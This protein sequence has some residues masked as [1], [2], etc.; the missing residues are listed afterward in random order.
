[1]TV[2]K[3]FHRFSRNCGLCGLFI[4]VPVT[5]AWAADTPSD[6]AAAP[7]LESMEMS[8]LSYQPAEGNTSTSKWE[9]SVTPYLWASGEKGDVGVIPNQEPVSIDLSFGDIF[10]NLKFAAMV[11]MQA[12]KDRFVAM[13]DIG[14][15][16][17]GADKDIGIRD[18]DFLEA[19]LDSSTFTATLTGGYRAMDRGPT[20]L[21]LMAGA[22]IT[23]SKTELSLTGPVRSVSGEVTET[24]VD[25]IIAT[26]FH[27]PL[28]DNWAVVIY[29]DIG[30]FGV[31]SD[32]TW[33]LQGA[34]QYRIA[35]NWWLAA[36]WRQY[37][38]DYDKNDF[39][40]D[41]KMGGPIIGV[42]Y[43]F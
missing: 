40:Y 41:V 23:S 9:F 4:T 28:A 5:A 11:I 2:L 10:D 3:S 6:S 32:L 14:Y 8:T 38:I 1:V 20:F 19:E 33:Q 31:S 25:P 36:G 12:R 30:G 16:K 26:R 34:I 13:A 22:R 17:V 43:I 18:P 42:T 27:T 7:A 21:D 39:I 37:A 24:W 35:Q 15:V 29:G